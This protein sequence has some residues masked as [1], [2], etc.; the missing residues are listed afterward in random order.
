[1]DLGHLLSWWV[2]W[3][4]LWVVLCCLRAKKKAREWKRGGRLEL[5]GWALSL[6][7]PARRKNGDQNEEEVQRMLL[8]LVG[9]LNLDWSQ[10]Q[11][12]SLSLTTFSISNQSLLLIS[13]RQRNRHCQDPCYQSTQHWCRN[14]SSCS[15]S[16]LQSDFL[17]W[18]S[19]WNHSMSNPSRR[20]LHLRALELTF[21]KSR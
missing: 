21:F 20:N 1:M 11:K 18:W 10:E 7:C 15:R 2:D 12:R 14:C 16:I 13:E 8:F 3:I 5:L 19:C 6:L 9:R 17:L 4:E